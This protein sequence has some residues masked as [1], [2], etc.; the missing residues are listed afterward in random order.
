MTALDLAPSEAS[1]ADAPAPASYF[2]G[3]DHIE[4]WVGNAR[5]AAQFLS[6]AFGFRVTVVRRAGDGRRRSCVVRPRAGRHP[7]RGDG[8]DDAGV[9][10]SPVT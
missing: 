9:R 2:L 4:L 5:Q 3:W 7:V 8:L 10:R 1:V 6:S